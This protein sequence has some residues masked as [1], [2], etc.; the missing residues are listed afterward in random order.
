MKKKSNK[1]FIKKNCRLCESHNLNDVFELKPTPI[2]DDY[3]NKKKI[4]TDF[5]ELK[6]KCCKNCGF[7][8]L[9]NVVKPEIVYG[10]YL[11]T[12]STSSGL[13]NHFKELIN[14]LFKEKYI[15]EKSKLI[16][17]GCNDGTLIDYLNK[18]IN[19]V[20]GVDPAD[21]LPNHLKKH[22]I[23]GIYGNKISS[24]IN[25]KYGQFDIIIANNVIANIDDLNETF[26]SISKNLKK[27]GFFVM[28][29]FS[30]YGLLK[31][32]LFDNIYHEHLSYFSVETL[33]KFLN[34][35][36][37]KLLLAHPLK[38]KGG[39]IRYIF[40]KTNSY[41]K[42][43]QKTLN[44]I[45]IEKNYL[46]NLKQRF[47]NIENKNK[48]NKKLLK[49]F[50]NKLPPKSIICGYGASVGTTTFIY[51]YE[52]ENKISYLFDDEKIRHNLYSPGSNI[53]ILD[54]KKLSNF[55][56]DMIIIFAWRYSEEII[57]RNKFGKLKFFK[58]LPK[59][60]KV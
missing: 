6:L 30:L 49:K 37:F 45:N 15:D 41:L 59:F 16:D 3:S 54:P 26:R 1:Y 17:I 5:F 42:K 23:R 11:Y 12:T 38:V 58:P 50:I 19:L 21:L 4:S 31:K 48:I 40:K 9:S 27:D 10:D 32:N 60:K 57:N 56:P 44:Y 8:Q 2:G 36:G 55:K 52:L 25:K 35:F 28:E 34:R 18:K 33:S 51:Y 53:K 13:S 47:K 39:S 29:T 22:L 24:L 14:Y 7:V 46:K 43:D 20:I